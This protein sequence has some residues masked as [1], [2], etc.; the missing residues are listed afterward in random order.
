M[1]LGQ[2][3]VRIADLFV[4]HRPRLSSAF[5]D[6]NPEMFRLARDSRGHTQ[7]ELS[8][9]SDVVQ[10][11]ISKLELGIKEVSFETV[12]RLARAL[13]Y[14]VSFFYLDEKYRGM[15]ISV[16]FYRKKASTAQKHIKRLQ[17]Q[18]NIC[19]INAKALLREA[20]LDTPADIQQ[21]D[22]TEFPGTPADVAAMV[23][24]SWKLPAGPIRN[25]IGTIE[26]AG[27]LVFRF[28]FGTSDIDAISQW[29]DDMPPLFF[30]NSSAPVDRARFSLAHE[31]GHMVMH[32][33]AS[34]TMEV[35]ANQ[36]AA[37]LLMPAQDIRSQ[38]HGMSLELAAKLK[39]YWRTSMISL[40]KRAR[41]LECLAPARYTSLCMYF[42]KLGYR[43]S[44]PYPIA[45][46]EPKLISKLISAH[47]ES[48]F[49]PEEMA[50]IMHL[51]FEEYRTRYDQNKSLRLAV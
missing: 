35:E 40:V 18:I 38:L 50:R 43:Q 23:R 26:N 33:S 25:L 20:S 5:G 7:E 16:I 21:Y 36:F 45:H 13:Q 37:A 47:I 14:P 11:T 32:Q 39:P 44:E 15:G 4:T 28:P 31:L 22:I 46:E 24:A 51:E 2:A 41:D 3:C 17:A 10:G 42:T 49:T 27:G 6:L 8:R 9:L 30:L 34:E 48:G 12:E 29:P 1:R 19:R